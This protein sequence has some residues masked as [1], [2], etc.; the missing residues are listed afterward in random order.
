MTGRVEI[1]FSKT[2]DEP[3]ILQFL[4]THWRANHIFVTHPE[5]L[6]WQHK[7]P[8]AP[9]DE[10]TFVFAR[11]LDVAGTPEI[12]GLLGFIPFRRF[13]TSADWSELALAIWKVRED[14][15]APGLGL[16]LLKA[17]ERKY[18]PALICAIGIS[19]EVEPIYSALGYK[20]GRLSHAA[21]FREVPPKGEPVALGVPNSA[22]RRLLVDGNIAMMPIVGPVLPISL[23]S[24]DIDRIG[25]IGLPRKSWTYILNRYVRHPYYEYQIRAVAAEHSLMAIVIWRQVSTPYGKVLRIVDVIGNS[26]VLARCGGH[27]QRELADSESEY[28]DLMQWGINS[29]TLSAGGFAI[30]GEHEGLVLPI[31]FEPFSRCKVQIRLA[32]RI[33][34]DFVDRK[35]QLFRADSDQDR[36]NQPLALLERKDSN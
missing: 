22:R 30:A 8:D 24:T 35:V 10:L 17:I 4:R 16:Q 7:S 21:L 9:L 32:F 12:V 15:E 1:R 14:V 3:Q 25:L 28:V 19:K 20:V 11:R 5:V 6:Q 33:A 34:P 2:S 29:Q 31:H 18:R 23:S 36:P 27:L 26:E 13:D